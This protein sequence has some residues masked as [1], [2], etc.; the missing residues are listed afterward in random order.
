MAELPRAG[1]RRLM[2]SKG[3]KRIAQDAV[4]TLRDLTEKFTKNLAK[5]SLKIADEDGRQTVRKDDVHKAARRIKKE[6]IGL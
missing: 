4:I 6:G 5:M 2:E 1:I 3:A